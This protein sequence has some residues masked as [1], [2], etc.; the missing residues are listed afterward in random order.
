MH[1]LVPANW[2]RELISPLSRS[3]ADIEIYGVLPTSTMGSG[4]SGPNIPQLTLDQASEFIKLAQSAGLTFN[5]LLNA[6]CMNNMEWHEATHRELL[7]HIDW[8]C[9][10]GVE[11]I[12]VAIPYLLELVKRQFPHLK[13]EVSTISHV[14]SVARAKFF[15]SLGADAIML[16]AN[17]NRDFKLLKAIRGAVECELGVLTNSSC[18][19]Q[20]PY[21]YYHNNTLGHASQNH[22]QL[23]GFYMDYCV[24]HCSLSNFS[25][26]SQFIKARW[27]RPEDVPIYQDL[28]IDFFKVGGRAMSTEW[29]INATEAYSS[30]KYPG[31][32]HDILNNFSPKTRSTESGLSHTQITTIAS[33]P[34]VYIDNQA[35]DGFI[36]FFKKQ[37]CLSE[38]NRCR[39][40]QDVADRVVK[41]DQAEADK[42]IATLNKLLDDLS[43][44]N[45][46]EAK[47]WC[48][49]GNISP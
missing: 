8:I 45:M 47:E 11:R 32:L 15:E 28:G 14:N 31:N 41:L 19:Y 38:C 5:Y 49:V 33:P 21:E 35:L 37:D 6:P 29:I 2:D 3:T 46:F 13:V 9:D 12:T 18:L 23:N 25:D 20:C 22:N 48:P 40:C 44:S 10:I 27:I 1:L 16:D 36:D 24:L 43:S 30:L 34:R 17:I 42:Y 7:E 26:T 39:Y 4:G